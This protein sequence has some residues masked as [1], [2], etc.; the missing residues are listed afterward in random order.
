MADINILVTRPRQQAENLCRMIEQQG[1]HAIRFPVLQI[2]AMN[3][4]IVKQQLNSVK[5]YDWLIFISANAV[6]FA[7]SA[8]NG[9]IDV[10]LNSSIAAVGKATEKAL[11]AAG[12]SVHLIPET[13]FNSEG[14]LATPEMNNISNKSCLIIRGKGGRETLADCLRRRGAQVDYMEVYRR[15]KPEVYDRTVIQ[16]LENGELNAMT[17]HSGEALKNLLAMI[18]SEWHKYLFLIPIIVISQRLKEIAKER[19]FKQIVVAKSPAD[20]AIIEILGLSIK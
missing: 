18:D 4:A 1:W 15:E 9:K 12:L 7:L 14:L 16:L 8:N 19:G 6:N 2:M 5:Q 10:F 17:M 11:K 3:T 20:A 13:Q